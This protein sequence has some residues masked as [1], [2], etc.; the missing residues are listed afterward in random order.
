MKIGEREII[1][2]NRVIDLFKDKL[3]YTYLGNW[4]HR[5]NSNVEVE[6][7]K[8]Y[9]N[10]VGYSPNLIKKAISEFVKIVGNQQSELYEIN[11]EVYSKLRYGVKVRENP[12]EA[13]KTIMFIDWDKAE[14]NDFYIA[15]EVTVKENNVK[16][17]DIVLYVNGIAL[18]VIELK[19]STVSVSKG[20]RQNIDNQKDNFIKHFFSTMGLI[21]AGND[22]QGIAY[23]VI[24]TAEKYYLSWKEDATVSDENSKNIRSLCDTVDYKLDK[25]IISL[26][27]K[28]RFIELLHD[29]IVFDRGT[30]KACRPNQYFGV[31]AAQSRINKREG[32]IIWH[33]QGSGK[34]LTMVWLTKWIKENKKDSRILIVT[35]RTELDEQIEK[36]YQK[37]LHQTYRY[38]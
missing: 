8:K 28:N 24:D 23:G 13:P 14:N 25:N 19:S 4:H 21:M 18:G 3:G 32:G 16:R 29:F 37:Q 5:E 30:K 1:T 33:T 9:L 17:P 2:Q 31:K 36:V 26:C 10:R 34:S 20:I 22:N 12:T 15:E 35:D 6:Y 11:K 38:E 7:L 27:E